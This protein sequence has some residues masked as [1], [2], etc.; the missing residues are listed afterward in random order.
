MNKNRRLKRAVGR[1]TASLGSRGQVLTADLVRSCPRPLT[2]RHL[3]R[4]ETLLPR[5]RPKCSISLSPPFR[6]KQENRVYHMMSHN[7]SHVS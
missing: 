5:Y 1:I 2:M 7:V 4:H 6:S 3:R